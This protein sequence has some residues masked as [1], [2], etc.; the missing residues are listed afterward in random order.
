MMKSLLAAGLLLASLLALVPTAAASDCPPPGSL[1]YVGSC[2]ADCQ[3]SNA[4]RDGVWV[5]GIF[6]GQESW[7]SDGYC[8]SP[9]SFCFGGVVFFTWHPSPRAG[10]C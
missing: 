9:D 3:T 6:I 4:S 2:A 5:D 10:L 8:G 7:S 1:A